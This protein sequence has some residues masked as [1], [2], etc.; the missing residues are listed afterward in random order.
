MVG[1]Q[2]REEDRV[3]GMG[4]EPRVHP[5]S[6][7]SIPEQSGRSVSG[8]SEDSESASE[9]ATHTRMPAV[10]DLSEA[11]S[12]LVESSAAGA[13]PS[14]KV[15]ASLSPWR[16]ARARVSAA[17]RISQA[18]ANNVRRMTLTQQ[19]GR[20]AAESAWRAA[21][22]HEELVA[23]LRIRAASAR[24]ILIIDKQRSTRKRRSDSS[25]RSGSRD[26]LSEDG[27]AMSTASGI[28]CNR[29]GHARSSHDGSTAS[30]A[31]GSYDPTRN[32]N[33]SNASFDSADE[34]GGPRVRLTV[35]GATQQARRLLTALFLA[36]VRAFSG[37]A[38]LRRLIN[39]LLTI[40]V[41]YFLVMVPYALAFHWST[42]THSPII[43]PLDRLAE[44]L[45]VLDVRSRSGG[46][47]LPPR[48]N[49]DPPTPMESRS[50]HPDG[51][52]PW[53]LPLLS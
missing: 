43:R 38:P 39:A 52:S 28:T 4:R 3:C 26:D 7:L 6:A 29:R 41:L 42:V 37:D 36:Y 10:T 12:Y 44:A 35:R 22:R 31:S 34:N 16:R 53:P 2:P 49:V 17:I 32:S 40:A 1:G 21:E 27:D 24:A 47:I 19:E 23:R 51:M 46:S 30:E 45:Y 15:V 13:K 33:V 14:K 48:W 20:R 50:S 5:V 11:G 18:S 8:R 25:R 9:T